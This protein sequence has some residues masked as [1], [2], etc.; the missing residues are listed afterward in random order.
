MFKGLVRTTVPLVAFGVGLAAFPALWRK[1]S[2][3]QRKLL[4]TN[5]DVV[6]QI[7]LLDEFQH[8]AKD[9]NV[10]LTYSSHT[11]PEQHHLSHVG[12]ALLQGKDLHEIDP[13]IFVDHVQHQLTGFYHL[14]NKLVSQDGGIHNG[15]VATI[16]DE[17]MVY[18][19][20]PL[21]PSGR[22]VTAKLSV[23]FASQAPPNTTVV[24]KT[25]VVEHKGRKVVV[26]GVLETLAHD[27]APVKIASA[28][29]VFVE[30][31]WFKY[32][33]WLQV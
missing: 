26:E 11:F 24:L 13:I 18:C 28:R 33:R 10:E 32:F 3:N 12:V 17:G 19:G 27:T 4:H 30:P 31:R 16:F 6:R 9:A 20:F 1:S 29:A 8:L 2:W 25:R 7:E 14:G 21:L 22:G 15:I 23:D 5:D